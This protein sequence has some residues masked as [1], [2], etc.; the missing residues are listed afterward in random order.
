MSTGNGGG[1][2]GFVG[3]Y[4][5][6][7]ALYSGSHTGLS[8]NNYLY[9][10]PT[11]NTIRAGYR[12]GGNTAID[13]SS[14]LSTSGQ[15]LTWFHVLLIRQSNKWYAFANGTL[16][17]YHSESGN[18]LQNGG[19][20]HFGT[21]DRGGHWWSCRIS[22]F[23]WQKGSDRFYSVNPSVNASNI[24]TT[25]FTPPRYKNKVM[26][27]SSNSNFS[28]VKAPSGFTTL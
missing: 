24:G 8:G 28:V 3:D 22:D 25:Y 1:S 2:Y 21:I 17:G 23:M 26:A 14:S 6:S 10:G 19:G 16:S 27:V 18:N 20:L 12:Y 7:G 15:L 5:Y 4:A 9:I 11:G 13:V